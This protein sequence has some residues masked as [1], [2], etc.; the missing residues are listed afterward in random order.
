MI[1]PTA[2]ATKLTKDTILSVLLMENPYEMKE[3]PNKSNVT[4]SV[5]YMPKDSDHELYFGWLV[6]ELIKI[7]SLCERTIIYCQTIKQC[8][9]IYATIKGMLGKHMYVIDAN[10]SKYVLVEMLHSCTPAA[11]KQ[12]ILHSFQTEHGKIRVLIATIAF[13]MGVDCK[14]VHRIVHYGPSKNLEAYV[15]ETGRAGRDGRQSHAYILYHGILLNHP[16]GDIKSVLKINQENWCPHSVAV[17]CLLITIL[18][19]NL[20]ELS[21]SAVKQQHNHGE[22]QSVFV[23]LFFLLFIGQLS[24]QF[25]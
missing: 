24:M 8:G 6:D 13:G 20:S 12:Q 15:Q 22:L 18:I 21:R 16:E 3:S 7:Q 23:I 2:T 4:Y 11:N 19:N 1:A 10:D 5:E 14:G 17:C 9:I 25:W